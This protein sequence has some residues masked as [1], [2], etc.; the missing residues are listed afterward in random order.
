M[1]SAKK[2]LTILSISTISS[3]SLFGCGSSDSD[4]D[5][6]EYFEISDA[7]NAEDEDWLTYTCDT[8]KFSI[9]IPAEWEEYLTLSIEEEDDS[10]YYVY[11]LIQTDYWDVGVVWYSDATADWLYE[12]VFDAYEDEFDS[13]T[14]MEEGEKA[15]PSADYALNL[16][17]DSDEE[18]AGEM[19]II[20]SEDDVYEVFWE[21]FYD[22]ETYDDDAAACREVAA[23]FVITD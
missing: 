16:V 8:A 11:L 21:V 3:L 19:Y 1:K 2:I 13:I 22:D 14:D 5:V 4:V 15:L 18:E 12:A 17:D 9:S 10:I 20:A 7:E 23:S 6:S